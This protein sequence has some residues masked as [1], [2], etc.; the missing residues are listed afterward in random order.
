LKK[1][2]N[3]VAPRTH[4]LNHYQAFSDTVYGELMPFLVSRLLS[5]TRA[6]PDTLFLGLGSSVSNVVFHAS[7]QSGCTA[8]GVEVM[9]KPTEMAR[10][11]L[12]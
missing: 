8:F 7:L 10:V 1:R 11:Q 4:E 3:T 6:D 12:A 5:F 2:M 9:E